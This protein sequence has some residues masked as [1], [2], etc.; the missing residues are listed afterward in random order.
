MTGSRIYVR[1]ASVNAVKRAVGKLAKKVRGGGCN[2]VVE[3]IH[4][5]NG[6][7][8]I[9]FRP[10]PGIYR[11]IGVLED[12]GEIVTDCCKAPKRHRDY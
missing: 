11:L 12:V 4:T 5:H 2:G 10:R 1:G 9:R 3:V 7:G 6:S 8:P